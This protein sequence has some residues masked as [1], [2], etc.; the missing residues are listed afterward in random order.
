MRMYDYYWL[1]CWKESFESITNPGV[2]RRPAE[3]A[4]TNHGTRQRGR[5]LRPEF[6]S[7]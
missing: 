2:T 4:D 3:I 5:H 1:Y 6:E 7:E